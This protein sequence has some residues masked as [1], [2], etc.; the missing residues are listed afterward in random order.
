M[1]FVSV[2]VINIY[3]GVQQTEVCVCWGYVYVHGGIVIIILV[4]AA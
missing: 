3:K 4:V 2:N 1:L